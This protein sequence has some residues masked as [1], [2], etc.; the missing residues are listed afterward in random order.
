MGE[1]EEELAAAEEEEEQQVEDI[2]VESEDAPAP[3]Q[4]V[5]KTTESLVIPETLQAAEPSETVEDFVITASAPAVEAAMAEQAP[6]PVMTTD[7]L[8]ALSASLEAVAE[9]AP[10]PVAADDIINE[11][12]CAQ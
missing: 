8:D 9:P 4:E 6:A 3:S 11:T 12:Q 10:V 2:L 1:L 5:T 7:A